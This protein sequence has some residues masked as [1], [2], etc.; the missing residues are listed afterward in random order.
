MNSSTESGQLRKV[1]NDK[2]L[3]GK[4]LAADCPSRNVLMHVT[5]RWGVLVLVALLDGKHRFNELKRKVGGVSDKM[6]AQTL[7]VLEQDGFIIRQ[8]FPVIPPHVEYCLSELG[9][10]V[11]FHVE[12]L[13]DWIE[14]NLTQVLAARTLR[15]DPQQLTAAV[16]HQ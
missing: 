16:D 12:H 3:R 10:Q 13:T 11:A 1:M 9:Q 6:L 5:S 14:E 15:N 2:V 8:E 4:V 7:Q